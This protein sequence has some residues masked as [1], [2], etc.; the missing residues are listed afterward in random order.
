MNESFLFLLLYYLSNLLTMNGKI[1]QY[2]MRCKKKAQA[3]LRFSRVLLKK[4]GQ[5]HL[6]ISYLINVSQ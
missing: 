6:S 2:L 4:G 1:E 3:S 5:F